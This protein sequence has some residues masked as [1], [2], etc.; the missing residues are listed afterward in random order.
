VTALSQLTRDGD[1]GMEI[2]ER[3]EGG[4]NDALAAHAGSKFQVQ[5]SRD[6]EPVAS[7]S[8]HFVTLFKLR[9]ST[10]SCHLPGHCCVYILVTE[11][12]IS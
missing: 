3:A 5:S 1:V 6:S 11:E 12:T 4:E 7:S 2:A 9:A 8:H 10:I